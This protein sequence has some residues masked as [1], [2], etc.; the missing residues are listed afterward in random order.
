MPSFTLVPFSPFSLFMASVFV[1]FLPTKAES[2]TSIMRSPAISPTFSDGPPG[3]TLFTC[4][5]SSLIVNWIPIPLKCPFSSEFTSSS[6]CAGIY[7]E[8]GSSS[9]NISGIVFS[10]R[11][12]IFTVSTYES[13]TILSKAFIL[14]DDPLIAPSLFP[15]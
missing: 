7:D 6:F 1:T 8:C 15:E 13:F 4:I 11:S 3:I 2:S 12:S 9:D 14:F 5:V 10:T